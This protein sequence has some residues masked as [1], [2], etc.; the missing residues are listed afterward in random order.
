MKEVF[1][2]NLCFL[3]AVGRRQCHLRFWEIPVLNNMLAL[4]VYTQLSYHV[5]SL[6]GGN[7][8]DHGPDLTFSLS[9]HSLSLWPGQYAFLKC[10]SPMCLSSCVILL[11]ADV[12]KTREIIHRAGSQG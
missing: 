10:L 7:I 2:G 9:S 5:S 6:S 4:V 3:E 8:P 11:G 12:G 1:E